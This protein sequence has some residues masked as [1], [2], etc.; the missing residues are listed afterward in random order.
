MK[1]EAG[2]YWN[3]IEGIVN[4]GEDHFKITYRE[5]PEPIALVAR[6]EGR[7]FTVQF[8]SAGRPL[9]RQRE[10]I[11]NQVRRSLDFYLVEKGKKDPWM[12]AIY[13]CSNASSISPDIHWKFYPK[14]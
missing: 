5:D 9:N 10:Q 8:I 12:Y 6:G 4:T 2:S 3:W 1:N 13:H 7:S 11:L 14:E